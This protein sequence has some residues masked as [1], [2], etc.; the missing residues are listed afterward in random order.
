MGSHSHGKDKIQNYGSLIS[1][2]YKM[3]ENMWFIEK[4]N[5]RVEIMIL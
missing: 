5:D 4:K 1:K 3:I 2:R